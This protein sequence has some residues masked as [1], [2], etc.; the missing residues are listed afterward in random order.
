MALAP[1]ARALAVA[2]G[3]IELEDLSPPPILPPMPLVPLE[4]LEL[5]LLELLEL[6]LLLFELEDETM[7]LKLPCLL[8]IAVMI[9]EF[10]LM[11]QP[12]SNVLS[13]CIT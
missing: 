9:D 4:L 1:K 12:M 8:C 6:E 11:A 2:P 10:V 7:A 3:T 5:L 13:V